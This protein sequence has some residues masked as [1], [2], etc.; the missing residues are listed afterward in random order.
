MPDE[1]ILVNE[2]N[3]IR[4]DDVVLAGVIAFMSTATGDVA[5]MKEL[6]TNHFGFPISKGSSIFLNLTRSTTKM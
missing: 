2:E 4:K 6:A 3:S 5:I 1:I